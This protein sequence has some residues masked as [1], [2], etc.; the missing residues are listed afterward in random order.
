VKPLAD[1]DLVRCDQVPVVVEYRLGP[2]Q[3]VSASSSRNADIRFVDIQRY[4]HLFIGLP[5]IRTARWSYP[6]HDTPDLYQGTPLN[7][8]DRPEHHGSRASGKRSPLP[9]RHGRQKVANPAQFV[10]KVVGAALV[11]MLVSAVGVG[12]FALVNMLSAIKPGIHLASVAAGHSPA[13]LTPMKGAINV[14]L[15][16]TDTRTGQ[17]G[18]FA[19]AQELAGSSGVGSND[20]TMVLHI[21]A[22]HKSATVI[23]IPR[24]LLVPVP[25]CQNGSGVTPASSS[26]M[27]NTALARGGLSCVVVTAEQLTGLTIPYAAEISFDGVIALSNSVGGVSV[28]LASPVV[29]PYTGLNLQA[30]TQ[31]LA[32]ADAL[33]FVRSRHGVGDGSDLGRISNQQLFLSSLVRK[34]T[35]AGV[36]G[37]PITLYSLAQAAVTN[38]QLSDTLT[39]PVTLVSI[40]LAFKNVSLDHVVFLQYP[41]VSDPADPGR[42][43]PDTTA[44]ATLNSALAA[45]APVQL[46]GAPGRAAVLDTSVPTATNTPTAVPSA[47][48]S[49]GTAT[50]APTPAASAAPTAVALPPTVT[51]QTAA[52]QTCTAGN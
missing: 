40:A 5:Q 4:S 17:G 8:I 1:D 21:S 9:V 12:S 41:A 45:D 29:D 50:S 38:M 27:F 35:S 34:I 7:S 18:Q 39:Q 26:A 3:W 52:Q 46:T 25:V 44:A 42:V 10:V 20:V 16:G 31:T 49:A 30:G 51:G 43:L 15:T 6:P 24:D 14:L 23:S 19:T 36:L 37:N 11:V 33:A 13:P 22:D 48:A 2:D 28:C 32:G 47:P